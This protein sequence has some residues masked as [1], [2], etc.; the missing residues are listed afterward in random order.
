MAVGNAPKRTAPVRDRRFR[1]P[2]RETILNV[3]AELFEQRGYRSTTMQDLAERLNISKATLYAHARSKNDLLIGIIEQ[4]TRLMARDLDQAVDSP[5][6]VQRVRL[7][8]KLWIERSLSMKAHRTVF[9]L[10]ASDHELAPEMT[11]RYR[12]WEDALQ[13]RLESLVVLAQQLGVVRREVEP[14]VA[15]A[16]LIH[17]PGWAAD[18][19]VQPGLMDVDSAVEQILDILLHGLFDRAAP[20]EVRP[21]DPKGIPG[22][23]QA[24]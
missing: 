11:A 19:L 5:S 14:V 17:A 13:Q 6:P 21:I 2:D 20:A 7:L 23:P 3:A 8:L 15:A 12:D 1:A 18:R 10:C 24:R 9:A 22:T 4:W 16:H